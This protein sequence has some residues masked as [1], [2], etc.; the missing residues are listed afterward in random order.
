MIF[1]HESCTHYYPNDDTST[2][3]H[4]HTFTHTHTHTH[5]NTQYTPFAHRA[6]SCAH[7]D[8]KKHFER[9][10]TLQ[11]HKPPKR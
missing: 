2:H 6:I 9:P 3:I 11:I 8:C 5:T 10:A 1:F 7:L 4:T